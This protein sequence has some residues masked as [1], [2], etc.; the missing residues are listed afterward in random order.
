MIDAELIAKLVA[1]IGD[2]ENVRRALDMYDMIENCNQQLL[3][4]AWDELK[5]LD[6]LTAMKTGEK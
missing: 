1:A 2:L 6:D 5:R 3:N 4:D